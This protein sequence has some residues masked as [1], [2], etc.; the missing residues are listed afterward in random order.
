MA[1]GRHVQ[2]VMAERAADAEEAETPEVVA[3]VEHAAPA[4]SLTQ[5]QFQQLLA[6]VGGAKGLDAET[7]E[8]I[9]RRTAENSAQAMQKALIPENAHHPGISAFSYPEGDRARPRPTLPFELYWKGFPIH[10]EP[11]LSAWWELEQFVHLKPGNY[12]CSKRDGSALRVTVTAQYGADGETVERLTVDFPCDREMR[13][14][15][16]PPYVMAYQMTHAQLPARE[17]FV[18]AMSGLLT[19]ELADRKAKEAALVPA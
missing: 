19:L 1:I 16:A 3:P 11:K 18:E 15:I 6:A 7:L 2:R 17:S 12:T 4:L 9:M 14:M 13:P 5:D 8:A 10:R